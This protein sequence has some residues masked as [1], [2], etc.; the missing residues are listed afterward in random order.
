MLLVVFFVSPV[1]SWIVG[2]AHVL[3]RPFWWLSQTLS[4]SADTSL[5]RLQSKRSLIEQLRVASDEIIRLQTIDAENRLLR[6]EHAELM[7]V[8]NGGTAA[9]DGVTARILVRPPQSWYDAL[10]I[11]MGT[12]DG[13][14]VGNRV[15]AY[16]TIPLGTV[17]EVTD[18]TATVELYSASSRMNDAILIP[19]NIPVVASGTGNSSFH[20]QLHRDSAVDEQSLLMLPTGELLATVAAVEFDTRDPFRSVRAVSAVNLQHIR[21]VTVVKD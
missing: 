19:G 11:D 15:Y 12:R 9:L 14:G 5:A 1:A 21:F 2:P 7:N 10:V 8:L 18:R 4:S 6:A 20:F 16:G 13:V 17:V 3:A